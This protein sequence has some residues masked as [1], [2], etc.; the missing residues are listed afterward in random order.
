MECGGYVNYYFFFGG[1]LF[2]SD[3]FHFSEVDRGGSLL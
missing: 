3:G 2:S 1:T